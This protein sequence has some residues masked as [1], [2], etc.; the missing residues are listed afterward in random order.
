MRRFAASVSC[1]VAGSVPQLGHSVAASGMS[2]P[3]LGHRL[4]L[5]S[6]AWLRSVLT[7]NSRVSWPARDLA[8]LEPR[9]PPAVAPASSASAGTRTFVSQLGH[10]TALPR[11]L[12]GALKTLSQLGQRTLTG[13]VR[14]QGR[15]RASRA[16]GKQKGR[17]VFSV[18]SNGPE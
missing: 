12:S 3:H 15:D 8:D 17:A 2:A 14:R 6:A 10:L 1:P 5:E 7:R 18:S 4:A 13:I 11:A 16:R 9:R